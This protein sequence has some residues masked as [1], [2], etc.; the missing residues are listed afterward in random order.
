M[1]RKLLNLCLTALFGA[2]STAAWA[3]SEVNGVYQISSAADWEEFAALVNGG[4]VNACAV[5]TADIDT[6]IDGTMIGVAD[7][8]GKRYDGTFDGQ[9]HTIKINLYPEAGDAGIFR[10]IGWRAIIQNLKVT[11]TITTSSKF[12]AGIV[13]RGRGIVRN[14]WS[15]VK[16]NSSVPGDAT[17][18]GIVA[19]GYSGTI[20]ENC[21]VQ[22]AIVGETTQN[23]GGVV[24]WAENP[25][26]IVNCLVISDES[27][28]DLSTGL[29]RNIARNDSRVK[30][31]DVET[32][33][34][35][36][37]ANRPGGACYN[38]YVTNDW[39]GSNPAVTVV[40]TADLADGRI[41]YQLNNDQSRIAWVQKLGDGGDPFPVPAAFGSIPLSV[42]YA[43]GATDCDG[44][45]E[46]ELT[47][48]NTPS[49][50]ITTP[51]QF[52]MY[53]VCSV[54]GLFNFHY[55]EFD[56]PTKFDQKDRAVFIT[57]KK[58][59]DVAEGM[60]RI[61]NGF[62]LNL[63][64]VNDIEYIADAGKYIFNNSDWIDGN[65]NGQGHVFTIGM[66]DMGDKAALFPEMAG[67]VENLI[68]H[69][70]ITTAGARAGS[71][72]GNARMALV[73]NVFSDIDITSSRLGDNTSGGMFGWTGGQEKRVEN[74][75]YAGTFTLPG[76]EA[77][78]DCARIGG[79]SGWTDQ[80]TYYTNCALL[81]NIIGAG[82]QTLDTNT[83]NS[84]NIG[85]NPGNV[86]TENVYV[87]NPI[88]GNAVSDHDKYIHYENEDGIK[89][90]ELAFFL[91]GKQNGLDRFYQLIGT[92]P[93]PMPIKK[94]GAL[95][96]TSAGQ[97]NC[98]GT[99][100]GDGFSYTNSPSGEAVIPPHQ[101]EDGW[102]KNCGKMDENYITPVDG[103]FEVSDGA[104]LAWWSNYANLHKDVCVRLTDDIDMSNYM[105]HYLPVEMFIGEFDGQGHTI[106]N[107]ILGA[108]DYAGLISTIADGA[109]IHDFIFDETCSISG[110]AF[111]GII[112][113]TSGAGNIYITNVGNEGYVYGT[114][115]NVCGILGVD[116]G[117]S[118]TLHIRNCWVTG[119]ITAGW[120]SAAICGYSSGD[121][122]VINCWANFTL[123]NSVT[124]K[125]AVYD[126]DSFTRGGAKVVNCYEADIEGVDPNKQ[127]HYRA[128]A[129]NRKCNALAVEDVASGA[130][131]YNLNSRQFRDPSWYQTL[132]E[133][134]HPYP[135]N[136]HGVIIG[137]G[138]QYFSVLSE[139]DLNEV[140]SA[141]Q[142]SEKSA[143]DDIVAT[144]AL[145]D[146]WSAKLDAL[147]EVETI[148]ALADAIDAIEA[149]KAAVQE[150]AKAYEAY[151]AK[152]NEVKAY[153]ASNTDF[154][155]TVRTALE[156][157]LSEDN[158]DE[159]SEDNPLGTYEYIVEKHIATIEEIQAET[160]RVTNWLAEAIATGEYS[161]GADVSGMFVN[162]DFSKQNEGWT[163]GFGK[164]F[165]EVADSQTQ[166][167]KI[168][169]VEAAVGGEGDM[170]QTRE[171]MKPGYYLIS[172]H[173]T[174]RP[175][176]NRYSTNYAAG[177]YA[178]GIFNYFP[179]AIED[180]VKVEDAQDGV[181]CNLTIKSAY[182]FSVYDDFS[183][184]S[185]EQAEEMGATLLGYVVQGAAG[186]AIAANADRYPVYTIAKVGED[187][188][189]T[190]G[191]K[192][193][194]TKCGND[195]TGWSSLKVMFCGDAES[196]KAGAALDK[197]LENMVA[198]ANTIIAY[199]I[200]DIEDPSLTYL[201]NPSYGP[202]FPEALREEL[203]ETVGAVE[204]AETVEAKAELV[205]KFSDIFQRI[206]EGKQ[207]Y[208]EL[209]DYA[210]WDTFAGQCN[211][212]LIE[213]DEESGTWFE[214]GDQLFGE[215]DYEALE[216][217]MDAFMDGS[218]STEEA[219]NAKNNPA[220]ADYVVPQ[221]EDGYYLIGTTKHFAVFRAIAS[222]MDKYAKGKLTA[223][224]DMN[225]I[226]MLPIGHNKGEGG[227]HIFAGEFDGQGHTLAN[228]II[229]DSWFVDKQ[230]GDPAALF[231]ELQSATAKNFKLTG[232]MFTSHQFSGPVTRWMSSSSTIDNVEI[233]VAFHLAPNLHGDTSSGGVIGRCGNGTNT[234]SNCLV[235]THLIGDEAD[236]ENPAGP[237]WYV[238]GV[239]GWSDTSLQLK[240]TLIQSEF[241]NVGA[242]GDNSRTTCR[243]SKATLTNVYVTQYFREAEGTLVTDEQLAS[244][245]I[246]YKL[247]GSQSEDVAWFQ[248]I[249]TDAT[250]CLFDGPTVYY[251]AGKYINEKPNIQLNA[252]AYNLDA[253]KVGDNVIV[254]FDLNAEAEGVE[255]NFY[256]G[257][258]KVYTAVSN[259]V[260]TAGAHS[261]V[262]PV[263]DLGVEDAMTL[264][265][266]VAVTGK[267]TLEVT[268]MGS[269]KVWDPYGM[270]INNNPASKNFGQA[271][272]AESW[273]QDYV[274]G[275]NVYHTGD[276][277]GALYAFDV[278]FQPINAAD[279]TPGF[280]G[281]LDIA[282]EKPLE[283]VNGNCLDLMDLR[284]SED[285]RLFVAR[286]GAA[287]NSSVWEINPEDL[288]EAW[289]PVFT[290]GELDE[291]TGITYV[292]EEEQNRMAISLAFEGKGEDLKMYVL[293][294]QRSNGE[295]KPTDFNCAFY[296][297]GTATEWAAAPSGYVEALD[298]KYTNTPY[299]AGIYAD[300][301]G[302][303]W[304]IQ[305]TS[306]SAETPAIKHFD[307]AGNE[308]YSNTSAQYGGGRMTVTADGNY[309]AIPTATNTVVLYETNYVPMENGKIFLNPKQ[310][311]K[312]GESSIASLAFDYA[313]NL[314]V[315]SGGTETFSRYTIPY[316]NK[317]VVTPG[318]GIGNGVQGDI[319]GDGEVNVADAQKVL[320]LM[321]DGEYNALADV[322][323]DGQLN[324]AD[325]QK[326]LIIMADQ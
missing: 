203:Q 55:W 45:S 122:E 321:A 248:T 64:M 326:V 226:A 310:T 119:T 297:L 245:E 271:L 111:V 273:V 232:E 28:F 79:F 308:D 31:I 210:N 152:C 212:N 257:E 220:L 65:F 147:D 200:K 59:I 219:L 192:S 89:N 62:K 280:Y 309:L 296:N 21:L 299:Q 279:G 207:A 61:C 107:F 283:I 298:G 165:E 197:V 193:P 277:V 77:G 23:C 127:Q 66:S 164:Y 288:N 259:D 70:T 25:C 24:G 290:G 223:D 184:T 54:C 230:E 133:D 324:V 238:G 51:H 295:L 191:I 69:G 128:M 166:D 39:G 97:F 58:D 80:K 30:A 145:I 115:Q 132:E 42:V 229:D 204:A 278:D 104:Q 208:L 218:Y 222:E 287:S 286:S 196:E 274:N 139:D 149:A 124:G 241:T 319:N 67:N 27:S 292:G 173:A 93:E 194:G 12:A 73:R 101:F 8:Q 175:G 289:K 302:G 109:N 106:S 179:A 303:L 221:D 291:Q 150:S 40:A 123:S 236:P 11:G 263:S 38:N 121:S 224:I 33:N 264:N 49:N 81:G 32:Y 254:D 96:Y 22:T 169:G 2:I 105:E 112:G 171:G 246:T 213:K 20:V 320:I 120:E 293:G 270:A 201:E 74:C 161:A 136:N 160:E 322:N 94:E 18:G 211:L 9:G 116:Q 314:Y 88:F 209:W 261:V 148:T 307:A 100:I 5:L 151:I 156:Y 76:A 318:N 239:A 6:G 182:D 311:I 63:K 86:V 43:S 158:F 284:F 137:A 243:G 185:D 56:D 205:A 138:D 26:N 95:V 313:G 214:T 189:L 36:I 83:E 82:N 135:F 250:P 13:G 168:F 177:I 227:V 14:C 87:V 276:K 17:H 301:Q 84:Q 85:R 251:Y 240:N 7:Q 78:A 131:C 118:M 325:A 215:I 242:D 60:N 216:E 57:S 269:Y 249:G 146:D 268:K 244:G 252:F 155:G 35:D 281:G 46:E 267:G 235:R 140:A 167:G 247:N 285:G 202:N 225:G 180:I 159:P 187:G 154:E 117:G 172:T 15:E 4:E 102:C 188:K 52:D 176:N 294:G 19:V 91:N 265:Y 304:F 71:I 130:L 108:G 170:Y 114:A 316:E 258:T 256:D 282:S 1:S 228:V 53:G 129:E 48:S 141:I 253:K 262:V 98:D 300:G 162:N 75:I 195:W 181:N 233:A 174:F 306:A 272:L 260:F 217:L 312:V 37:Y 153:L 90:G 305:R 92:D 72:S 237:F 3:L 110:G 47:F 315:A 144:Q 163:G 134:A 34:Q 99:P 317:L 178:N 255:V 41:C 157:Y 231:Y 113:G 50:A 125:Q 103:W 266:E 142:A 10:Y 275:N 199:N 198:R 186:M 234:V 143:I 16:I 323:G 68:L 183:S 29:S 126:C 206:Y 190:V 44:K